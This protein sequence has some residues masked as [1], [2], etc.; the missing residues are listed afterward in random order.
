[1]ALNRRFEVITEQ[2]ADTL[3]IIGDGNRLPF[4]DASFDCVLSCSVL[5]HDRYFCAAPARSIECSR[6]GDSSSRVCRCT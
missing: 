2:L 3:R 5:E 1:V 4:A 6:R